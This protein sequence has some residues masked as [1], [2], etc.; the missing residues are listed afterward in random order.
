MY[1]LV[2]PIPEE[3]YSTPPGV[4]IGEGYYCPRMPIRGYLHQGTGV[5]NILPFFRVFGFIQK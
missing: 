5:V 1:L 2:D 3:E 4:E